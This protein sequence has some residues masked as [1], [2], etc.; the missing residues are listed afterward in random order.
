MPTGGSVH[1]LLE[2]VVECTEGGTLGQVLDVLHQGKPVAIRWPTWRL[3]LPEAVVGYPP[4]RRVID[5]PLRE[6]PIISPHLPVAEALSRMRE[7]NTPYA[8]ALEG[9][10][11]H[12]MV[13]LKRLLEYGGS[14]ERQ[15]LAQ[16]LRRT[17]R[18]VLLGQLAST[19][20]HELR[21]QLGTL[22]LHMDILD[23]EFQHA[24]LESGIQRW[25]SWREIKANV[26][27]LQEIVQDYLSLARLTIIQRQPADL[28]AF[29]ERFAQELQGQMAARGIALR[30]EGLQGLGSVAFHA[31][32][33]RRALLNLVQNA[34]E[35]MPQG[36]AITLRG[37]GMESHVQVEI[38]DTGCGIPA[39]QLPLLFTPWYTTKPEG[40]GLGLYVVHEVVTAHGGEIDAASALGR[41]TTFRLTLP[42][43]AMAAG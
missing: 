13:S 27:R 3:L 19:V 41:G 32:T 9:S 16:T 22:V 5:L 31:G 42:R 14:I 33:L 17:E 24:T 7:Q 25:E 11:L 43:G 20:A 34:V 40:T 38:I 23:E 18:L 4:T 15:H 29:L 12:G 35:A 28:G 39:D 26:A 2:P 8:L 37:R 6:A 36:G 1:D 21:N 30:C 10:A